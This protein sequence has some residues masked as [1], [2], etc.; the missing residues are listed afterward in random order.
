MKIKADSY[1]TNIIVYR[2]SNYSYGIGILLTLILLTFSWTNKNNTEN[3]TVYLFLGVLIAL[4]LMVGRIARLVSGGYFWHHIKNNL[5]INQNSIEL[6]SKRY[7]FDK[8]KVLKFNL[9]DFE[10]RKP[11][12]Y[13]YVLKDT[14]NMIKFK[15][16]ENI[17]QVHF[18]PELASENE[19]LTELKKMW[20]KNTVANTV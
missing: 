17:I 11:F 15:T 6:E 19:Y 4:S 12:L 16:D 5:N 1:I 10:N 20:N 8:I 7:E 9:T 13:K 14:R 3:G 2:L 18:K